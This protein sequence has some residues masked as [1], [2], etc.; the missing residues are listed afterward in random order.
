MKCFTYK[1][2]IYIHVYIYRFGAY[3]NTD[4]VNT[5]TH[6]VKFKGRHYKIKIVISWA[7]KASNTCTISQ[8]TFILWHQLTPF[9]QSLKSRNY[10]WIRSKSQQICKGKWGFIDDSDFL[11]NDIFFSVIKNT[12]IEIVYEIKAN[13]MDIIF[14]WLKIK[15]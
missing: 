2:Y 3:Q 15:W 1:T 4:H 6:L 13:S 11:A 8:T 14:S 7:N 5:H 10:R 9:V 12:N